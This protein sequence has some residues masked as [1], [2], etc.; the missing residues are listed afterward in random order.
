MV[1][2]WRVLGVDGWVMVGHEVVVGWVMGWVGGG[3]LGQWCWGWWCCGF[4]W[5]PPS[6]G[7]QMPSMLFFD[8]LV[9][10]TWSNCQKITWGH[11]GGASDTPH[12]APIMGT[13]RVSWGCQMPPMTPPCY[14]LAIWWKNLTTYHCKSTLS[15]DIYPSILE[16]CIN[17]LLKPFFFRSGPSPTP[18]PRPCQTPPYPPWKSYLCPIFS[19]KTN[20]FTYS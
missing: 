13:L 19:T 3:G 15:I 6:W 1:G 5:H 16:I 7:Y 18:M 2:G 20:I 17:N 14:F 8:N 12:D 4:P 10:K 11:H 9:K